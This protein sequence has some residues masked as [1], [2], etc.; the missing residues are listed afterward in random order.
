ML[1]IL[2]EVSEFDCAAR[3]AS[4][5]GTSGHKYSRYSVWFLFPLAF[6]LDHAASGSLRSTPKKGRHSLVVRI[7]VVSILAWSP[8]ASTSEWY[9]SCMVRS[10]VPFRSPSTLPASRHSTSLLGVHV[11]SF[12]V[13]MSPLWGFILP[14][15]VLNSCPRWLLC[16][17]SRPVTSV[18]LHRLLP[19]SFSLEVVC[20]KLS[21]FITS[22]SA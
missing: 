18:S 22:S 3:G 19:T 1:S 11:S 4:G 14:S 13:Y 16:F 17:S 10:P 6:I 20:A 8:T 12:D 5:F 15:S 7:C 2:V 9:C 21:D